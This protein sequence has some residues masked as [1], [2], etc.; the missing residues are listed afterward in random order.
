MV[1]RAHD[2]YHRGFIRTSGVFFALSFLGSLFELGFNGVIARLPEG[3]YGIYGRLFSVFFIITI[4]FVSIQ[5]M[6]S[7]EVSSFLATGRQG[8]AVTFVRRSLLNVMGI[9]AGLALFGMALSRLIADFLYIESAVPVLLLMIMIACYTPFPVLLGTVQGLK[10]F[11]TIGVI[12]IFWGFLRFATGAAAFWVLG[13]K[14]NGILAGVILAVVI[15]VVFAWTKARYIVTAPAEEVDRD[16]FG[17]AYSLVVPIAFTLFSVTVLRS[18]DLVI[19]GRFFSDANVD[20]YTCAAQVGKAFFMLTSIIIV[21]FP[22]VSEQRSL[23]RDPYIYLVK[24]LAVTIGLTLSGIVVSVAAPGL[25]MRIITVGKNIPGSEPLI[26]MVGFVI[27]PVSIIYIIA[28]YLLAQH[29]TS[30]IPI[31]FVGMI[32]Q[33]ILILVV[34]RTPLAMLQAV[35]IANTITMIIMLAALFIDKRKTRGEQAGFEPDEITLPVP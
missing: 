24:S 21:M 12:T 17:R 18:I 9:G 4:P 6:V 14:L 27:L 28:N 31:L 29:K 25:V 7:K 11:Y 30:F 22:N 20:A 33:V 19:A 5:L 13:W 32:G 26:Q 3:D 1:L 8:K 34:H 35:G 10:K 2:T 16:E 23:K 15:T